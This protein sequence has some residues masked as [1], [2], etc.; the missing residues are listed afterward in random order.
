MLIRIEKRMPYER[1]PNHGRH[2]LIH[3]GASR[4]IVEMIAPARPVIPATLVVNQPLQ[5]HLGLI[6]PGRIAGGSVKTNES[7]CH[8][9]HPFAGM[10][11]LHPEQWT[12][13][14]RKPPHALLE[15]DPQNLGF[16]RQRADILGVEPVKRVIA[17][18]IVL[19]Q[20][21]GETT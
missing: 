16:K 18:V 13:V 6:A 2:I 7:A 17:A 4:L 20:P 15:H 9:S 5:S 8:K 19:F 11:L 10:A 1:S 3:I 12:Q 21:T 14:N